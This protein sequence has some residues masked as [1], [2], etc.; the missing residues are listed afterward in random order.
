MP[1]NKD[2]PVIFFDG[3]CNLCNSSVQFIIRH[4]KKKTFLFASLQS[5]HGQTALTG[6][7]ATD[8]VIPDSIILLEEGK[9]YT[10]SAAALRIARHLDGLW[11]VLYAGIILPR[12][13]RDGIYNRIS[14]NRYKWFGKRTEC[15]I[16]TPELKERF[17]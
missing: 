2:R 6:M 13:I 5:E 11:P 9:Y 12:F 3:M 14:A 1:D 16:P 17:L 7:K 4:D 10:R 8:T 15:M